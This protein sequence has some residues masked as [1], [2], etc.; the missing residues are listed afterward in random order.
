M[1]R[2][3]LG[4]V[5]DTEVDEEI[6]NYDGDEMETHCLR[7]TAEGRFYL[8]VTKLQRWQDGAWVACSF[9][10]EDGDEPPIRHFELIRPLTSNQALN[11]FIEKQV[12]EC[13]EP[14]LRSA[15]VLKKR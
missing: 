7:R 2:T 9:D 13:F 1:K 6:I 3:I 15:F 14:A 4:V 10:R 12:P 5:Y 8:A 11:W